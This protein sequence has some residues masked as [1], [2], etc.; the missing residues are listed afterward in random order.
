MHLEANGCELVRE[1]TK[2]YS[3][4]RNMLNRNISGVPSSDPLQKFTCCAICKSLGIEHPAILDS[5]NK[6]VDFVQNDAK[7]HLEK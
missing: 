7:K 4:Y 2:G 6:V 1:D 5:A 3:V